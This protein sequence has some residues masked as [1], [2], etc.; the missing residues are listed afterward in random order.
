MSRTHRVPL[1]QDI[2]DTLKAHKK[3]T[4]LGVIALLRGKRLEMPPGLNGAIVE[5]WFQGNSATAR[6]SHIDYVLRLWEAAPDNV[7]T[8]R[9]SRPS[10]DSPYVDVKEAVFAKLVRYRDNGFTPGVVFKLCGEV[11]AG[12]TANIV[13]SWSTG[14]TKKAQSDYL[15][16]WFE[17]CR[18]METHPQRPIVLTDKISAE[19]A[20]YIDSSGVGAITLL[21]ERSD[22][23]DK[24]SVSIIN[25]WVAGTA[26]TA[27]HDH[28]EYVR[29][30]YRQILQG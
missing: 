9:A 4:G 15:E 13:N 14:S 24:L 11:P 28:L 5:S 26:A 22:V 6:Q 2:L 10:N 18:K 1:T 25:R 23:P 30:C 29:K 20:S 8:G 7:K 21:K 27:C 3:R 16:Y 12:L 17:A 19:F